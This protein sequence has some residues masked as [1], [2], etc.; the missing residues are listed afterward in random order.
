MNNTIKTVIKTILIVITIQLLVVIYILSLKKHEKMYLYDD[1]ENYMMIITQEVKR[2]KSSSSDE[3]ILGILSITVEDSLGHIISSR[4]CDLYDTKID[5]Q[6]QLEDKKVY[7][8]KTG[9]IDL[10]TN[11][12]HCP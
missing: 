2:V 12:F 7:Y 3:R 8:S 4:D 10:A 11:T 9:Y 1:A 6:W 5:V